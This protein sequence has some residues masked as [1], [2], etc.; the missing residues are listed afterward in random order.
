MTALPARIKRMV[1]LAL[2]ELS[3]LTKCQLEKQQRHTKAR[4]GKGELPA[5]TYRPQRERHY[6][7]LLV[8]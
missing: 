2:T 8:L 5:P 4:D 6:P 7:L 3:H 1:T